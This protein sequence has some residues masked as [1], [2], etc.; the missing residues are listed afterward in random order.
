MA[1]GPTEYYDIVLLGRTGMGKSTAGNKMLG[2]PNNANEPSS[3]SITEFK[4]SLGLLRTTEQDVQKRFVQ[5]DD[6]SDPSKHSV[7]RCQ[8][9]S[10]VVEGGVPKKVRILDVPGFGSDSLTAENVDP[11]D[12]NVEIIRCVLRIQAD[13]KMNFRRVV[14]FLPCRGPLEKA[15][16]ELQKELEV[17]YKTF[18]NGIFESMILAGTRRP[19]NIKN[20]IWN[21][22][23][24]K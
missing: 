17:M 4:G 18:G 14:Y 1:E 16:M 11:D 24:T 7:T 3:L 22:A 23:Q 5:A 6:F 10:S 12:V 9:L 13:I 2:L 8:V 20:Q 19:L 21:G 15:D